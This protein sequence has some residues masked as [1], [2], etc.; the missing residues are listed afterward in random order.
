MHGRFAIV[1]Q[2]ERFFLT[3]VDIGERGLGEVAD[4]RLTG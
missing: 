4:R 2:H 3:R 1:R